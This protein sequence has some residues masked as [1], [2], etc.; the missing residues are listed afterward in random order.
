[1]TGG[2]RGDDGEDV[3]RFLNAIRTVAR[4]EDAEIA[5]F[6]TELAPVLSAV[7]R[8][9]IADQII[10][11]LSSTGDALEL[12]RQAR[13]R[14]RRTFVLS[15]GGLAV[16]AA[17]GLMMWMRPSGDGPGAGL[18]LYAV[19]A[20]GGVAELRGAKPDALDAAGTTTATQRLRPESELR[21]TCRPDTAIEGPVAVRAFF[22]QGGNDVTEVRPLVVLAASG[23]AELRLRGVDLLGQHRGHGDLRVVVGRPDAVRTLDLR[24]AIAPSG[25]TTLRWL[26]VPLDLQ[27]P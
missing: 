15:A 6:P 13:Q 21:V 4:E 12:R 10:A 17:A 8:T 7:T 26:T 19:S 11:N 5:S 18:P 14:S 2:A 20:S 3:N 9:R 25:A 23:A 22:V 24:A 16:A 1:M 27:S